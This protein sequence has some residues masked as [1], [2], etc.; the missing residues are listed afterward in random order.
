MLMI[1]KEP[2]KPKIDPVDEADR[3]LLRKAKSGDSDAA[4]QLIVD[5]QSL[6]ERIAGKTKLKYPWID[7]EDLQQSLSIT[8]YRHIRRFDLRQKKN[9]WRKYE[10]F[11]LHGEAKQWLR[12]LDP[13]GI[14]WPHRKHYPVHAHFSQVPDENGD[15]S[16]SYSPQTADTSCEFELIDM[17]DSILSRVRVI[18]DDCLHALVVLGWSREQL[19]A[20]F[21]PAVTN[22]VMAVAIPIL[23]Q[24][25]Q[26]DDSDLLTEWICQALREVINGQ[27]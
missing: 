23:R 25:T 14:S 15:D 2:A 1:T 10:Y 22:E 12:E 17:Y 24:E 7:R 20:E 16:N 5:Q 13:L 27:G 4:N 18:D 26:I 9:S 11:R 6:I 8:I 3:E 19:D 21:T